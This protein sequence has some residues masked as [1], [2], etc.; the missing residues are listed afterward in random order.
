MW[1]LCCKG[2]DKE[3]ETSAHCYWNKITSVLSSIDSEYNER[4]DKNTVDADK[5]LL[6]NRFLCDFEDE[7]FYNYIYAFV[8]YGLMD[9]KI[10]KDHVR[11]SFKNDQIRMCL[12]K[13]GLILELKTYLICSELLSS[14]RGD[15]LTG[16]TID[17]DGEDD[18]SSDIKYLYDDDDPSSAIDT[19]NEIDVLANFGLLPY[20]ISCKNG[21]FTSEELYKLYSV[22]ERFGKGY[23][24]KIIVAACLEN[25]LGAA[26]KTI[27]QRAADMGII[28]VDNVNRLTDDEFSSALRKAMELPNKVVSY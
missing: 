12:T 13:A 4:T 5:N 3:N 24:V 6:K 14:Q 18:L 22:S 25:S 28:I 15:C 10:G 27:L 23:G 26:R 7:V 11:L 8:R 17:W 16:V 2:I 20:F 1:S 19:T 21:K 9:F